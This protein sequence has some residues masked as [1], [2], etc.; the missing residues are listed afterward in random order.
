MAKLY[1]RYGAMNAGKSTAIIQIAHN[2]QER[3]QRA[4][5]VKPV[6]DTKSESVLSRI[7]ASKHVDIAVT[8]DD[9]LVEKVNRNIGET[10]EPIHCLLVDEVQFLTP[11]QVDELLLLTITHNLPVIGYGLRTDFQTHSFPGSQ[12]MMELAHSIEEMKTICRCGAKAIFNARKV[13]EDFMSEGSQVAIDGEAVT[14]ESLCAKCYHEKVS[15]T[16]GV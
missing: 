10:G 5:I 9:S 11:R 16:F 2:Y 4:V 15:A 7:G 1:F 8:D 14:Y 13:G 3:G 12:R 6:I